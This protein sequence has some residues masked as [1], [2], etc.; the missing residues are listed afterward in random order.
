MNV[1]TRGQSTTIFRPN[2]RTNN[3]VIQVQACFWSVRRRS[4][5]IIITCP[6]ARK[7]T[8]TI[9]TRTRT[10][11]TT[12]NVLD[13]MLSHNLPFCNFTSDICRRNRWHW[14]SHFSCDNF[15]WSHIHTI[16]F[17]VGPL[18]RFHTRDIG[19]QC[20]SVWGQLS[21]DLFSLEIKLSSC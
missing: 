16:F 17:L 4:F 10:R 8:S 6:P 2:N 5:A 13:I 7:I 21:L 11:T 18:N 1:I 9:T 19:L 3:H 20:S 15:F 12:T 14:W